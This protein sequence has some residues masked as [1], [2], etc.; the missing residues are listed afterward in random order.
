MICEPLTCPTFICAWISGLYPVQDYWEHAPC[1]SNVG[2]CTYDLLTTQHPFSFGPYITWTFVSPPSLTTSIA[3]LQPNQQD[4]PEKKQSE[5]RHR[6][7]DQHHVHPV[8]LSLAWSSL[9]FLLPPNPL[10]FR[11]EQAH[12]PS[13]LNNSTN[14][15]GKSP[16]LFPT[17]FLT[18]WNK[19]T[20]SNYTAP[21]GKDVKTKR[22]SLLF[23]FHELLDLGTPCS[24]HVSETVFFIFI[25]WIIYLFYFALVFLKS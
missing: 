13:R 11:S 20:K 21:F 4:Q 9:S 14:N 24:W 19:T 10:F 1:S 17:S 5:S 3:K 18:C 16:A 23:F 15:E 22:I 6:R 7:G 25:N 12:N 2:T 8:R